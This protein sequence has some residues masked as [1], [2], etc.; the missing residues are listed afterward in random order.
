MSVLADVP[1][2]ADRLRREANLEARKL[3]TVFRMGRRAEGAA[4]PARARLPAEEL[5]VS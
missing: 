5:I 4:L 1:Y 3:V 2:A